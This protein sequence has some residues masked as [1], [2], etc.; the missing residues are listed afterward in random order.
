ME[1]IDLSLD[2]IIQTILK[3]F[4]GMCDEFPIDYYLLPDFCWK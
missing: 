2:S 1:E 4:F 3:V